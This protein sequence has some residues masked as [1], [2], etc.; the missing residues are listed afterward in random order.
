LIRTALRWLLLAIIGVVTGAAIGIAQ[1][2]FARPAEVRQGV[3]STGVNVGTTSAGPLTRAV[4]A[5]RGLLALPKSE[6]RYFNAS[7]DSSGA[8]LSGRCSYRVE[9]GAL[10]ARW[11]SVT[12]YDRGG[13][14][15]V[16]PYNRHSVGS[17][18]V[19]VAANGR[20]SFI[21]APNQTPGA[22][23][24]TATRDAFELTLRTYRPRDGLLGDLRGV[25]LP[26]IT[27]LE[28]AA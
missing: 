25:D 10:A 22:W 15:I 27:K 20:W 16:N 7:T 8:P 23:I 12:V 24:P 5:L 19:P 17:A 13:W 3:W 14:L 4:V 2:R 6:A 11:W 9:G 18:A 26:T 21:V 1:V 28:C